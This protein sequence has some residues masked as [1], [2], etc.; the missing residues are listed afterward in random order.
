[1]N[2]FELYAAT[3]PWVS[4]LC[5]CAGLA[6]LCWLLSVLTREYSWVDRLWS[7]APV[8][9]AF[10]FAAFVDFVSPRINLMAALVLLWGARLTYN[11][12]RKGGY[13]PGGE[14]YRWAEIKGRVGPFWFQVLNATFIAPFQNL[15]LLLIVAPS[16]LAYRFE[17]GSLNALDYATA[18]AFFAPVHRRGGRRRATVA[19][20]NRQTCSQGARRKAGSRVPH[21]GALSILPPSQL[22]LRARHVVD[23]LSLFGCGGRGL[24]QLD[25]HWCSPSHFALP[26]IHVADRA[27]YRSKV[28]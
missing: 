27:D 6:L 13:Q 20:P 28:P 22:L 21:H 1:M 8:V 19:I 15:L 17:G 23:L 2:L 5:F 7:I 9:Y 12:A 10:H 11:F 3:D 26:R 14:D 4:A 25:D 16:Y 18:G 24:A